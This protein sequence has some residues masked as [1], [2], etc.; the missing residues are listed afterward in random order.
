MLNSPID[1]SEKDAA[2]ARKWAS[3]NATGQAIFSSKEENRVINRDD[4]MFEVMGN[5]GAF[6]L[7][8]DITVAPLAFSLRVKELYDVAINSAMEEAIEDFY[9]E[10]N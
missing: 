6:G 4:V 1:T 5:M 9:N 10:H 3:L 8:Y 7:H 2:I